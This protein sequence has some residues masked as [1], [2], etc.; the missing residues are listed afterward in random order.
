MHMLRWEKVIKPKK[1]GGLNLRTMCN[2]NTTQL[3]KAGWQLC[4]EFMKLWIQILKAKYL[5]KD[6][7]MNAKSKMTDS[8]VWKGIR[9][10][11]NEVKAGWWKIGRGGSVS[12]WEVVGLLIFC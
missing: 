9:N 8:D 10:S 4:N 5:K 7:M 6:H 1:E 12:F 2:T 11:F 3:S